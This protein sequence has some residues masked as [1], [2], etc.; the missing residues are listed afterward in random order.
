LTGLLSFLGEI[1]RDIKSAG[2]TAM[3]AKPNIRRT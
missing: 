3:M 2:P 1:I